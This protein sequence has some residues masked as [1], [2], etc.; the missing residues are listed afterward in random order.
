MLKNT[1]PE[2]K[3]N[4]PEFRQGYPEFKSGSQFVEFGNMNALGF[5]GAG[6][7]K[8]NIKTGATNDPATQATTLNKNIT[9]FDMQTL[10]MDGILKQVKIYANIGGSCKIKIG[11]YNS[12][13]LIDIE[14]ISVTLVTGLNTF[15]YNKSF[16]AQSL[17]GVFCATTGGATIPYEDNN[18][19]MGY[20]STSGD[21]TGTDAAI[22]STPNYLRQIQIQTIIE[23]SSHV[24]YD[25]SIIFNKSKL[26]VLCLNNA[27]SAWTIGAGYL[28]STGTGLASWFDHYQTCN[29]NTV[30]SVDFAFTGATDVFAFYTKP[31][32]GGLNVGEGTIISADIAN[33]RLDIYATFAGMTSYTLPAIVQSFALTNLTLQTGIKYRLTLKKISRAFELIIT[34][35]TMSETQA[36]TYDNGTGITVGFG[37]GRTGF[38][39]LVGVI[40][41]YALTLSKVVKSPKF[42]II[43]DS[44]TEASNSYAE[45]A[46]NLANKGIWSG[47][48]GTFAI[49]A[50]RRVRHIF[51]HSHPKYVVVLI[52]ANNTASDTETTNFQTDITLAYN[53]ILKFNSIPL[54]C[55]LT[56]SN[57][58]ERITRIATCNNFLIAQGWKLIRFDL[59]I[60]LNNDGTTWNT[61]L[62]VDSLHPNAAGH[63][64]LL[65]RLQL[66]APEI[67]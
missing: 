37:Y 26:P 59:A 16:P 12:N 4:F 56:P 34:D 44:I 17:I 39:A 41:V 50:L 58:V 52:G 8:Y 65:Q 5:G 60:S 49:S 35:T 63:T 21:L 43:G 61:A 47:D 45:Q 11:R 28:T 51:K 22:T 2:R 23:V 20:S 27:S 9:W 19:A 62:M 1:L 36:F 66:D 33:N 57:E 13:G 29:E 48:G 67:F 53:E 18:N 14:D 55:C 7:Q 54:I 40:N 32:L 30:R 46:C 6:L 15:T 25:Y 3:G 38:A 31:I 10:P 24:G 42:A 64:L